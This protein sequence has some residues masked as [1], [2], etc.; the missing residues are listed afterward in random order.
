MAGSVFWGFPM[1]DNWSKCINVKETVDCRDHQ[2][3]SYAKH[4]P[5]QVCHRI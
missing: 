1:D 4:W 3:Q 2:E 5:L